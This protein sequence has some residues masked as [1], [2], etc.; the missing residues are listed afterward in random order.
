LNRSFLALVRILGDPIKL[1]L[2]SK[3]RFTKHCK[4]AP[5]DSVEN[6]VSAVLPSW[7]RDNPGFV[8]A[9]PIRNASNMFHR[10]G[11]WSRWIAA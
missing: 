3:S 7:L 6:A 8:V 10:T 11:L 4:W 2:F 1:D 9:D 5:D